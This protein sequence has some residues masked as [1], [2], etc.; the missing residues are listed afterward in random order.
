MG[1]SRF[2]GGV[3]V[4]EGAELLAARATEK[5]VDFILGYAPDAPRRVIGD[6]GRIRQILVNLAG[7]SIKFTKRGH[8]FIGI[9]GPAQNS[10][11]S[12][13]RFAIED[14]GIGIAEY[15]LAH[16]FGKFIQPGAS[17]TRT[18]GGTGLC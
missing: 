9:E 17:T 10:S 2:G 3:G 14:T 16:L 15:K 13:F 1:G 12:I 6:P 8:V 7:N 4:E 11:E 5:G 18:Y